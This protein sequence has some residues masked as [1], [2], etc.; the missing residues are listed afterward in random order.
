MDHVSCVS[1]TLLTCIAIKPMSFSNTR[2]GSI[3]TKGGYQKVYGKL[4]DV[5]LTRVEEQKN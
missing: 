3:I 2:V 4:T 1:Y 5:T